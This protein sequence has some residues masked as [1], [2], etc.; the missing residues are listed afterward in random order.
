[1]SMTRLTCRSQR[2]STSRM[3]AA[4]STSYPCADQRC[5]K[6]PHSKLHLTVAHHRPWSAKSFWRCHCPGPCQQRN[7][8]SAAPSPRRTHQGRYAWRASAEEP[9][10]ELTW[11]EAATETLL[12]DSL[13]SF[14]AVAPTRVPPVQPFSDPFSLA[15]QR[16]KQMQC[17]TTKK[18]SKVLGC[19]QHILDRG[20]R[21]AVK[22]GPIGAESRRHC[23]SH[24]FPHRIEKLTLKGAASVPC[25]WTILGW[26][27]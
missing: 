4:P 15:M 18:L 17:T 12:D 7:R 20:V 26:L 6:A 27:G 21:A 8:W 3:C 14:G 13:L 16:E 10:T 25:Q 19:D 2:G 22:V 5:K 9:R 11:H 24:L 23:F 1:M